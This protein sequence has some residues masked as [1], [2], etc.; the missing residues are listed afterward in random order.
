MLFLGERPFV[1]EEEGCGK[2]FTRN[3]ELTRHRRIHSGKYITFTLFV[4]L[5]LTT[6]MFH[7]SL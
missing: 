4:I 5:E 7:I 6:I 2:S 1:C 3:E